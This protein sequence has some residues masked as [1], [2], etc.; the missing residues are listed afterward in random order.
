MITKY[1]VAI[2]YIHI[3][4]CGDIQLYPLYR[5]MY[6]LYIYIYVYPLY[7]EGN[8]MN[9]ILLSVDLNVNPI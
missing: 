5:H 1:E 4:L 3:T 6:I 2:I 8:S 9:M 7:R